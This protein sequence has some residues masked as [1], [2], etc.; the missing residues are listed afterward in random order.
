MLFSAFETILKIE[1]NF[2]FTAASVLYVQL[3]EERLPSRKTFLQNM[4]D[5]TR[6]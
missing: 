3:L 4:Q 5:T 6:N 2:L 1:C